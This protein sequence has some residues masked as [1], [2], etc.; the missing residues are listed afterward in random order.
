MNK[1]FGLFLVVLS[2]S[3]C[4]KL[5]IVKDS[6]N[7]VKVSTE[8]AEMNKIIEDAR[9]S[10]D[11]FLAQLNEPKPSQRD[12]AVKFPFST[13]PGS[14]ASVEHIWLSRIH[15]TGNQFFGT[16]SND[17]YYIKKMKL[18]DVV[19]FDPHMI[20][21]WKFIDNDKLVGGRSIVFML[22]NLSEEERRGVLKDLDYKIEEFSGET[23]SK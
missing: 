12:F 11:T 4:Q 8:D 15:K 1:S 22:K 19:A 2:L 16:V 21:D 10:V 9:S 14:A 23:K 18:G 3:S 5:H 13:D 20:S 7:V 6:D 17:P